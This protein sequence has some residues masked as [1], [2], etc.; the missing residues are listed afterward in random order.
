MTWK[1]RLCGEN[2]YHHI[3][4]WGNDRHPVF[5]DDYHYRKYLELLK[6]Y[7]RQFQIDILA[8]ALMEWHVHLFL[9]DQKNTLSVFMQNLHGDYAQYFNRETHRVGHVFG[10]RFNNRIVQANEY[11]LWLTRY[12][13]RQALEAKLVSD[14]RDY[15]WTSYRI[16]LGLEKNDFLKYDIIFNQFGQRKE[17]IE[18]YQRFVMDRD[19]GPVD[20]SDRKLMTGQIDKILMKAIKEYGVTE[21]VL[22]APR[23]RT[24]RRMRQKII[25]ALHHE[26]GCKALEL[27]RAFQLSR[28]AIV[29]I[30][31]NYDPD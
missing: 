12:I 11:G 29:K 14:P 10:E 28:T 24:A 22:L 26:H 16:Y 15:P 9:Y 19:N 17:A 4:A 23:G 6:K 25:H 8:Y 30:L 27:A 2:L 7:S 18:D 21:N 20:W 3:Y 5:K 31:N 1:P 13:H